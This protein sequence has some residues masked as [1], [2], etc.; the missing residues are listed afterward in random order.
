MN[1]N[2]HSVIA[3]IRKHLTGKCNPDTVAELILEF[4]DNQDVFSFVNTADKTVET[5][6]FDSFDY[7]K[8]IKKKDMF[9]FYKGG[10]EY[11]LNEKIFHLIDILSLKY[12]VLDKV[13]FINMNNICNYDSYL[14]TI[15]F[16]GV[17][18]KNNQLI[19]TQAS[20]KQIIVRK[21]KELDLH[22][23][24]ETYS[25][26]VYRKKSIIQNSYS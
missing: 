3:L 13:Y 16:F 5:I 25:P 12:D 9:L 6:S 23:V 7:V 8:Y 15:N 4:T 11:E 2:S 26:V 17:E 18:P 22:N 1:L 24:S 21:G 10:L 14:Q 20:M 19:F